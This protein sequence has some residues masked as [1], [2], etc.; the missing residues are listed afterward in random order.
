M[1]LGKK[2]Q[3]IYF[4]CK[5]QVWSV[6]SKYLDNQQDR[7]DLF[8]EVF[9]K[10]YRALPKFRE[11]AAASTWVYRITINSALTYIKKRDRYRWLKQIIGHF[12]EEE[13]TLEQAAS[14]EL[15]LAPLLKLN[16]QQKIILLLAEVEEKKLDEI[17][18]L[19]SL[20]LGT[21]KSTLH[22]AREIVKK[23]VEKNGGV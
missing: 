13:T 16:A 6:I 18:E 5:D 12:R 15:M 7:E 9:V 3:K 11:E 22:R 4:A 20:P 2:Y 21:V 14:E 19:L 10:V 8:Q 1:T 23:E 17:A